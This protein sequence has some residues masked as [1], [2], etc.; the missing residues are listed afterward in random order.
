M[1][2]KIL[3]AVFSL[4]VLLTITGL[5][6]NGGDFKGIV[7]A[8]SSDDDYT[9]VEKVGD[10][11][12]KEIKIKINNGNV[13]FHIYD[14]IGYKLEYYESEYDKKIVSMKDNVL[15]IDNKKDLKYRFF[16]ITFTTSKVATF[17]VYLPQSFTGKATIETASGNISI[18][19]FH[20]TTLNIQVSSGNVTLNEVEVDNESNIKLSSGNI[21]LSKFD[22]NS[23]NIR[24]S[25]GNINIKEA[26][27][28]TEVDIKSSSGFTK[29]YAS[30]LNSIKVRSSSGFVHI[31]DS[32]CDDVDLELSSGNVKVI[33]YGDV[34]EYQVDARVTSGKIYYQGKRIDGS[35]YNP[36][37]SKALRIKSSSGNIELDF[38][39]N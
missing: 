6:I 28:L 34:N 31:I 17:N 3:I 10:E 26:N 27:I 21:D 36:S 9:F 15:T 20:F 23:L 14:E 1:L 18:S 11:E 22:A 32:E 33:L 29:V 7:N 25:S 37:G 13:V 35:I 39:E 2:N 5:V 19:D 24:S 16:N 38:K 30:K 8:F 4:G 12:V